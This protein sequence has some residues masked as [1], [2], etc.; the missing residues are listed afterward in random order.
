MLEASG[1]EI[2]GL[3]ATVDKLE[4]VLESDRKTLKEEAESK[5]K[6]LQRV[7]EADR[8]KLISIESLEHQVNDLRSETSSNA[9]IVTELQR[10]LRDKVA[11][12]EAELK[13]VGEGN[14][15]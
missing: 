11:E 3:S 12:F 1:R 13:A 7:K 2:S 6:E 15:I 10:T 5:N 14:W 8:M 9:E 4:G